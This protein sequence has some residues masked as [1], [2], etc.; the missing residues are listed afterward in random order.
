MEKIGDGGA[1][2]RKIVQKRGFPPAEMAIEEDQ[3]VFVVVVGSRKTG[4]AS[5]ADRMWPKSTKPAVLQTRR[6]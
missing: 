4:M 1:R 6:I 5:N 2:L 3:M